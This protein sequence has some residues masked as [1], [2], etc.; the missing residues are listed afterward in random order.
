MDP[1]P[2]ALRKH[3]RLVLKLGKFQ[4]VS[5]SEFELKINIGNSV[6]MI[7]NDPILPRLDVRAGDI[8]TFY[9]EVPLADPKPTPI[10]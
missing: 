5:R 2:A 6:T 8:L 9:T 7:V 1:S 3:L 10:E 4:V